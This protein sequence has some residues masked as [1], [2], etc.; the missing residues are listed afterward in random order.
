MKMCNFSHTWIGGTYDFKKLP[1]PIASEFTQ[2]GLLSYSIQTKIHIGGIVFDNPY[3]KTQKIIIDFEWVNKT[4]QLNDYI[5][6]FSREAIKEFVWNTEYKRRTRIEL[7]T[8]EIDKSSENY[9]FIKNQDLSVPYLITMDNSVF[10]VVPENSNCEFTFLDIYS[11]RHKGIGK[12]YPQTYEL[13]SDILDEYLIP[14]ILYGINLK[15]NDNSSKLIN[16]NQVSIFEEGMYMRIVLPKITYIT[17]DEKFV[18]SIKIII[19]DPC[20]KEVESSVGSCV[21]HIISE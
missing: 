12:K 17:L 2:V 20:G 14:D 19:T 10:L 5:N 6:Q 21:L 7:E 4:T 9:L 16:L 15:I 18:N 11:I 8:D 13:F 3:F 1:K